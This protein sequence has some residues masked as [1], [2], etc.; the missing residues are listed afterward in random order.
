M[1]TDYKQIVQTADN[2]NHTTKHKV[3]DHVNNDVGLPL[4]V[5]IYQ[6]RPGV[7]NSFCLLK[8]GNGSIN[9]PCTNNEQ[10]NGTALQNT[11]YQPNNRSKF[12]FLR[13]FV[14]GF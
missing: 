9:V 14:S 13:Q 12:F 4:I 3:D 1:A 6:T 7:Q 11:D 2:T 10:D 8:A 5:C